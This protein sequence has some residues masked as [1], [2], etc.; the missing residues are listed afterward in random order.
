[1]WPSASRAHPSGRTAGRSMADAR[2]A[3][4]GRRRSRLA[5][6]RETEVPDV[7][8][9]GPVDDHVIEETATEARHIGV[10]RYA[11]IGPAPDEAVVFHRDDEKRSVGKPSQTRWLLRHLEDDLS[12]AVF[13]H[14]LDHMTMEVAHVPTTVV[15]TRCFEESAAVQKD[16]EISCHATPSQSG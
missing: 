3:Q 9:A 15:P 2:S 8:A 1:M 13:V 16:L 6:Q 10:M 7:G 4:H 12:R 5:I 11:S 14:G